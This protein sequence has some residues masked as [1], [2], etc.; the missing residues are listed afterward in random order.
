MSPDRRVEWLIAS[1]AKAGSSEADN[2]DAAAAAA[3]GSRF[4]VCDGATEGW[5][6]GPWA[7]HL[8]G[9]YIRRVPTPATFTRW[10]EKVRG[11]WT[12]PA[13][14]GPVA[15]YAEEKQEQGSFATLLGMELRPSIAANGEWVWKAVAVGDSCVIQLRNAELETAF[16]FSSPAA[17][18]TWPRLVP[19]LVD[20]ACPEPEWL[21]GRARPGD[22]FVLATDAAAARLLD[23]PARDAACAVFQ[24]GLQAHDREPILTWLREVQ[25]DHN[26]DATAIV[27]RIL[28]ASEDS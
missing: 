16:P 26:D 20:L 1:R 14:S 22:L 23:P 25:N 17:F 12:P 9:A 13:A 4:A 10:L 6:S 19:S 2:E 11:A 28:A 7:R 27:I 24:R 15:W 21:A 8:A 5:E 3:D 18:D